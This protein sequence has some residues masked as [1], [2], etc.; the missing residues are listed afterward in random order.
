MAE[1][2]KKENHK[3]KL[4]TRNRAIEKTVCIRKYGVS[5]K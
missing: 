5:K 1:A 4:T 2:K 3:K